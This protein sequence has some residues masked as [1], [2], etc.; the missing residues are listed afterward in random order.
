MRTVF[1]GT[2]LFAAHVLSYLLKHGLDV[3]AVVTK[4]DQPK[5][6]SLL[7]SPSPM[8]MHV[9]QHHS[10]LPLFSPVKASSVE[11][12]SILSK[13]HP[14]LFVV[15]A[16][17]KI[18]K[19]NLLSMPTYG[20]INAHASLLPAYRGAAPMQRALLD[21]VSTTGV[22]IIEMNEQMDAGD[23]LGQES[24]HISDSM[25]FGELEETLYRMTGPLMLKVIEK[26]DLG[27][28]DR[29]E[30][31]HSLATFAPKLSSEET[32]LQWSRP[33]KDLCNQIRALSPNPGAW[34]WIQIGKEKKK[35]KIKKARVFPASEALPGMFLSCNHREWIVACG[36]DALL[37]LE[38]QLEGKKSLSVSSFLQGMHKN[39]SFLS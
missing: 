3:L 35:I 15:V 14:E 33:A 12:A 39:M 17:G 37:I 2:S 13:L 8:K 36:Q 38:V 16:Y 29:V 30:Q 23:I 24:V 20:C 21:G 27:I 19:K 4:P 6:R 18:I 11:F 5:G 7:L 1:F 22:T 32:E 28:C 25:N 10:S 9:L 26:I 31:I 34:A